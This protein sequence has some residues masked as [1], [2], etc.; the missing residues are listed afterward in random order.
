[1]KKMQEVL[2]PFSMVDPVYRVIHRNNLLSTQRKK[3]SSE[4]L[5]CCI[6]PELICES[7]FERCFSISVN[8]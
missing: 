1:M 3:N 6:A 8:P 2:L 5:L 4:Q 7:T